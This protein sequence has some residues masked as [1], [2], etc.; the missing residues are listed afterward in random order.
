MSSALDIPGGSLVLVSGATGFVASH[1]IKQLLERGYRV[2][3]TVRDLEKA[4]WLTRDVFKAEAA[5]GDFEL[6][7][8]T[9]LGAK[10]AFDEAV[11]GGVAAIVHVANVV[12]PTPTPTG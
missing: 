8:V 6:V 7:T 1:I 12:T 2:R 5:R 10:G 4:A 9:D 11:G 3:G